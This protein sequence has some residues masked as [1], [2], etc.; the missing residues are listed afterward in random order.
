MNSAVA[1]LE[2][3]DVRA[4]EDRLS[5]LAGE[6]EALRT[7]L[8]AARARERGR[9]APQPATITK[10]IGAEHSEAPGRG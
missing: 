8:R 5:E 2:Q 3:L 6:T 9:P 10:A 4:L 7:L 1:L